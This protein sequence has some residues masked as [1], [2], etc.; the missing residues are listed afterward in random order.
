MT[1][2]Y[3][4]AIAF[5]GRCSHPHKGGLAQEH[6][7]NG[8]CFESTGTDHGSGLVSERAGAGPWAST[9]KRLKNR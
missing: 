7:R 4:S 6:V 8:V 1:I 3:M 9:D 5:N 2:G